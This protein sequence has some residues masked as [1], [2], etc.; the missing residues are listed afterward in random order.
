MINSASHDRL[1]HDD[2]HNTRSIAVGW[3]P[4]L[5]IRKKDRLY[6][7]KVID[8]CVRHL[9]FGAVP[10]QIRQT[11]HFYDAEGT[12]LNDHIWSTIEREDKKQLL[13]PC[14]Y[15]TSAPH[16]LSDQTHVWR[17]AVEIWCLDQSLPIHSSQAW[18]YNSSTEFI[19]TRM[20]KA[21]FSDAVH[22]FQV[23]LDQ[24]IDNC[25]TA[26]VACHI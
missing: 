12:W 1:V 26:G 21:T 25:D 22:A 23:I 8:G 4:P 10:V 24:P 7:P 15:W 16:I 17:D 5:P 20:L 3:P 9:P 11:K 14:F 18:L 13:H 6:H 19:H 2:P